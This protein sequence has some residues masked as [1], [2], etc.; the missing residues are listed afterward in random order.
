[1][2]NFTGVNR[3]FQVLSVNLLFSPHPFFHQHMKLNNPCF[4]PNILLICLFKYYQ[5]NYLIFTPI[6]F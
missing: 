6:L 1:M 2:L 4:V 5:N 3:D